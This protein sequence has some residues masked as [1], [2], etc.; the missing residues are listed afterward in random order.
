[1]SRL[2][3]F[4]CL[5]SIP[6]AAADVIEQSFAMDLNAATVRNPAPGT[7]ITAA[8][9]A[10]F[11]DVLAPGLGKLATDGFLAITTGRPLDF[12]VHPGYVEA[13]RRYL[14]R[15]ALGEQPGV[16]HDYAAGRPFPRPPRL[17]DPRAGD[18]LAWNLRYAH[19]PDSGVVPVFHWQYR[20]MRTN[21]VERRLSFHAASMR[22]MYRRQQGSAPGP[23]ENPAQ[24]YSALYLRALAPPDLRGTQL[25]VQRLADD[26]RPQQTWL[27]L[28]GQR[29]VRR[30]AS[31]Q[32]TDAFLGSDIMIED[33]L[34]Y[35]GRIMDQRWTY[36]GVAWTL[37]PFFNHERQSLEAAA[38]EDGY[39][40][41]GFHGKGS[42]FP[43][44]TW[45][46]R[47]A[48]ILEAEPRW[49]QHPLSKRR[50]YVDAQTMLPAYGRLFDRSGRL[51]KVAIG[52][53]AHPDSHHPAN[54]GSGAAVID[55]AA[56]ID[57]QAM[58]CTTLQFKAMK[59]AQDFRATDFSVQ[60]L[61]A[62]GR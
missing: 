28:A 49:K 53:Y 26:T 1:M 29:R 20:N 15:P 61:R 50:Y 24:I 8:N 56:M 12:A 16:L 55:A 6:G 19:T 44:V 33:F 25:L 10:S 14:D 41:V 27:Y 7:V 51:W 11:R 43:N 52:A 3:L 22:F 60:S 48:Y 21:K 13:S 38:G 46:A 39:R 31:G 32:T 45:H 36:R 57:L 62:R 30:L 9:A 34:G 18:K 59:A 23:G 40:F 17:D 37:L 54:H 4:A 58:R 2:I 5:L 42:C 47:K 35:N